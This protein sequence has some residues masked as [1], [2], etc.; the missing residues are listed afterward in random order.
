MPKA[1]ESPIAQVAIASPLPLPVTG[2]VSIQGATAGQVVT[3]PIPVADT[4][5]SYA[6]PSGVKAFT[7]KLNQGKL[8][9]GYA[10]GGPYLPVSPGSSTS[11]PDLGPGATITLYFKSSKPSDVLSLEIFTS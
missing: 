10:S 2:T 7:A 1:L 6:L 3:I 4:E 8:S 9:L 5:Q 11:V